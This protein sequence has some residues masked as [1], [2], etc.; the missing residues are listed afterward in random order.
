M[1]TERLKRE[2]AMALP[3]DSVLQLD[4]LTVKSEPAAPPPLVK[5]AKFDSLQ[6]HDSS[7]AMLR[8]SSSSLPSVYVFIVRTTIPL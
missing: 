4:P 2:A 6:T 3:P 5:K 7:T 8:N 1:A